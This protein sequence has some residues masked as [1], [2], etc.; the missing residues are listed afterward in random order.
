M[1][2]LSNFNGTWDQYID[3]FADGI[4]SGPD[5]FWYASTKYPHSIPISTFKEYIR[6]NQVNTSY[7]YN[8]TPGAAQRDIKASLRVREGV[9]KLADIHARND[10]AA[11]APVASTAT[12]TADQARRAYIA[13]LAGKQDIAHA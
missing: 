5:A 11:F 12:E 2:F 4:P 8:A 10:P 7:Y 13:R 6:V 9:L 3:A 1:L